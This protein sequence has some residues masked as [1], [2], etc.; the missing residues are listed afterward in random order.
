MYENYSVATKFLI[1]LKNICNI[2]DNIYTIIFFITSKFCHERK[3]ARKISC[4]SVKTAT[5]IG[6]SKIL[7][8]NIFIYR[9]VV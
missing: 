1:G 9:N 5:K 7:W 8:Q 6:S 3:L 4:I 2:C